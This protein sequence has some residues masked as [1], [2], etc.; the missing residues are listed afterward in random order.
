MIKKGRKNG[1]TFRLFINSNK[2][3][4]HLVHVGLYRIDLY[5][6]YGGLDL[7]P[8]LMFS[9]GKGGY[10]IKVRIC[11]R[12]VQ[13]AWGRGCRAEQVSSGCKCRGGAK[14]G[15]DGCV[16]IPSW[17]HIRVRKGGGV[18]TKMGQGWRRQ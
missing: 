18:G 4:L 5:Q 9:E 6:K 16:P 3:A 10:L 7:F 1:L 14:G 11:C 13:L 15:G 12:I 2:N 17:Y 8:R